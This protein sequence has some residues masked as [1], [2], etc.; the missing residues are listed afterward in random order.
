[1]EPSPNVKLGVT[2]CWSRFQ[3]ER[4]SDEVPIEDVAKQ[5]FRLALSNDNTWYVRDND[6]D[7]H[8][9][10]GL[11]VLLLHY[12]AEHEM[13]DRIMATLDGLKALSALFSGVPVDM[14]R[15]LPEGGP[16]P[17]PLLQW[18]KETKAERRR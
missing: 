4:P 7:E 10:I 1:M 14:E 18:F 2:I 11:G 12:A 8:F 13:Y 3:H 15:A 16:E 9:R 6:D 5:A 17:L